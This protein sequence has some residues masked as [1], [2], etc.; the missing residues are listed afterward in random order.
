MIQRQKIHIAAI[1]ETH[2][3]HGRNHKI[4]GYRI[5]TTE[6]NIKPGNQ[7][8]I[9]EGGVAILIHGD[10]EQH[11]LHIHRVNHR[12]AKLTLRSEEPHTPVTILNTY[13]PRQGKTKTDQQDLW[14]AVQGSLQNTPSENFVI[15]CADANGQIEKSNRERGTRDAFPPPYRKKGPAEKENGKYISHICYQENKIP[16]NAWEKAPLTKEEKNDPPT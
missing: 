16:A 9:E 6:A 10:M 11:I 13:A 2:I 4:N 8:G 5:I 1:Q 7:Q 15:W 14:K 3:P 12:I